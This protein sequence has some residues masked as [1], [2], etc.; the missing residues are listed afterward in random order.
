MRCPKC[1]AELERVT[2]VPDGEEQYFHCPSCTFDFSWDEISLRHAMELEHCLD[3]G[4]PYDLLPCN[5][6]H[7][8]IQ[9]DR[10]RVRPSLAVSLNAVLKSVK[11]P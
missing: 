7:A 9:E 4:E 11:R 1:K 3:C 10:L 2:D 5:A 8:R 6:R